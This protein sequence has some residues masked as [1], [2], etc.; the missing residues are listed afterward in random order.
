MFNVGVFV[1]CKVFVLDGE[2]LFFMVD[3]EC[4]SGM[5]LE[6]GVGKVIMK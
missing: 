1:D 5:W 3:G 6:C 2:V 4:Y